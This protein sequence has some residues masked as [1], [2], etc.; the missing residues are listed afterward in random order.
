MCRQLFLSNLWIPR[1][2]DIGLS[3]CEMRGASS[4]LAGT[5]PLYSPPMNRKSGHAPLMVIFAAI[6]L[7]ALLRMFTTHTEEVSAATNR[8]ADFYVAPD[9]RDSWSGT[10]ES[11]N[12]GKTDGPFASLDRARKAVRDMKK[13]SRNAPIVVALRGGT[14]F[15]SQPLNFDRGDSGTANAPIVYEAFNNEKPV[16]SGG[17][18]LTGWTNKSGNVWTVN[19]NSKDFTNFEALF[20][21]DERRYRPRTTEDSYLYIDRPVITP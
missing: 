14:Y 7:V 18:A 19:L 11:P 1:R 10:L 15:M 16:I 5:Y 9:G 20:F 2:T 12:A 13:G 17:R 8:S 6:S 4:L 21:N 3:L